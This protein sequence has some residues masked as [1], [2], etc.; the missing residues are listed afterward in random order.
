MRPQPESQKKH[1]P[2]LERQ[3]AEGN[4]YGEIVTGIYVDIKNYFTQRY[5]YCYKQTR[6]IGS[7][8]NLMGIEVKFRP[9]FHF[10][11]YNKIR[12]GLNF[13]KFRV[14]CFPERKALQNMT[15]NKPT[16]KETR[17]FY[18]INQ[19]A[20]TA[21]VLLAKPY[22]KYSLRGFVEN[23]CGEKLRPSCS[24]IT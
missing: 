3:S 18:K 24:F 6:S 1:I 7:N 5:I 14:L 13:W 22:D 17:A 15:V 20:A 21:S 4:L 8:E 12:G 23:F 10:H 9:L 2:I 11:C 16:K 19:H